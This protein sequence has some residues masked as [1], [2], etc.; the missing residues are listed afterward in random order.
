M[1]NLSIL[2]MVCLFTMVN[3]SSVYADAEKARLSLYVFE[4]TKLVKDFYVW[5]DKGVELAT[6]SQVDK[7]SSNENG[8]ASFTLEIGEHQLSIARS[9]Y[10]NAVINLNVIENENIQII[11]TQ[12]PGK[13]IPHVSIE[14]S[15]DHIPKKSLRRI[16]E[17]VGEPGVIKGRITNSENSEPVAGAR[18]FFSGLATDFETDQQGY[19]EAKVPS[20]TYSISI[21]HN[22]FA[23]Q[24][25]DNIEVKAGSTV[26]K[27]ITVTPAGIAL[28]EFVVVAP[29]IQGSVSSLVDERKE[30]KVVSDFVGA[31][32]MSKSGDSDAA[33][34][35]TRVAG[36]TLIDGKYAVI[37]GME[38]RYTT[39]LMNGAVMRSPDPNSKSVDLDM[40]PASILD[41]IEVQ[42]TY[43]ADAPGAFGG[44]LIK[45][46]TKAL[47]EDDF[48]KLKIS[49][50]GNSNVTG[51]EIVSQQSGDTDYLGID[52]G[53]RE[54]PVET[55]SRATLSESQG[56]LFPVRLQTNMETAAPN[57]GMALSFGQ[58]FNLWGM[59]AGYQTY[60]GYE[61]KWSYSE[62]DKNT[63]GASDTELSL[64]DNQTFKKSKYSVD[65][66]ALLNVGIENNE[67][68]IKSTTAII[69]KSYRLT[70]LDQGISGETG[71][72]LRKVNL[73]WSERELFSQQLNGEH[74]LSE[75]FT[76][77]WQY[78]FSSTSL[79]NPDRISYRYDNNK[80][81]TELLYY[82]DGEARRD[83][84]NLEDENQSLGFNLSAKLN[85]FKFLDLDIKA[86]YS[87][88]NTERISEMTRYTYYW[89]SIGNEPLNI[90]SEQN[91][92]NVLSHENISDSG[93]QLKNTTLA[94]DSYD[95]AAE[96]SGIYGMVSTTWFKDFDLVV[97]ARSERFSQSVNTF[98]TSSGDPIDSEQD[99]DNLLPSVL[100]TY[101]L[102]LG[103]QLR[104]ALAETVNRPSMLELS[105][106]VWVDPVSGDLS[107]GNPRLKEANISHFDGRL[108][109]Y[110]AGANSLSLAFFSKDF[111]SP[112]ERTLKT[113]S[114]AGELVTYKNA[115]SASNSGIEMDFRYDLDFVSTGGMAFTV[116]GNYSIIE[117]NVV[118]PEGHTEYSDT[119]PMQGQS[120][121]TMNAMLSMDY[122]KWGLETAFILNEIGERITKVGQGSVPHVYEQPFTALD[123]TLSQ[124]ISEGKLSFKLKNLLGE[125][126]L[127]TQG[128]EEYQTADPG[129]SFSISYSHSF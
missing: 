123:F 12:Y 125:K 8:G 47:P 39:V 28:T 61:K 46:R 33:A 38:D 57:F 70:R 98:D 84:L 87:F 55:P 2:V 69:R 7:V 75:V 68:S 63:Y 32:Q 85:P 5:M 74:T 94:S 122:D 81:D 37:R 4:E 106:S 116:S 113:S 83:F 26:E 76:A 66:T 20:S 60:L 22:R 82:R 100:A 54:L 1:K 97:G 115:K 102:P 16:M 103:F 21:L 109:W 90:I 65:V 114:G 52:D 71:E 108:E 9:G 129:I 30:T 96:T 58:L 73:E 34:A 62:G 10:D 42:K 29:F 67:H 13:S 14:S 15:Q 64:R 40:F 19:F 118:L 44:G 35:L 105:Q 11:V 92:G 127:F 72:L 112:I 89:N 99:T 91:I 59:K 117:S 111:T 80:T 36:L 43:S 3:I 121:Y 120:P 93:F 78:G 79:Y 45:L 107:I 17:I 24:T 88:E 124:S 18:L 119:R 49:T 23:S 25:L 27:Q 101:R 110:G 104:V 56:K 86:G 31:E 95:A 126:R 77:E 128:G 51:K 41:S 48:F 6:D 50:G 53:D